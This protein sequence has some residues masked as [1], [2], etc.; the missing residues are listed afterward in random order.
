MVNYPRIISPG[1]R[2]RFNGPAVWFTSI[3]LQT[4]DGHWDSDSAHFQVLLVQSR[5]WT[6]FF[7]FLVGSQ[8]PILIDWS[9]GSFYLQVKFLTSKW[10]HLSFV[11]AI[12]PPLVS[13][14]CWLVTCRTHSDI[15]WINEITR[16]VIE[17]I[18]INT[19]GSIKTD[20]GR[21]HFKQWLL[22]AA[23]QSNH[24]SFCCLAHLRHLLYYY[25]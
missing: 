25:Y 9:R 18:E 15:C 8:T 7:F 11:D 12:P 5:Y 3:V 1:K 24:G 6:L 13:A 19:S 20:R 17:T 10:F 2:I 22:A 4:M 23:A 21:S 16:G 14:D